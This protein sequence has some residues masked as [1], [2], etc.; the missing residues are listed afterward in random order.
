MLFLFS[1]TK[2]IVVVPLVTDPSAPPASHGGWDSAEVER[3]NLR[4]RH[5]FAKQKIQR[6]SDAPGGSLV[7]CILQRGFKGQCDYVQAM[8]QDATGG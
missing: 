4:D 1:L 2:P 7:Y 5:T 3:L 8:K 6:A